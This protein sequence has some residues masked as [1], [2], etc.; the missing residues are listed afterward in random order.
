MVHLL[1]AV[2]YLSF[3]SLGLPDSL[4]GAAWPHI[5]PQMSV[6]VSYAGIISFIIACGTIV[7]SLLSDRLTRC[8]G[9]GKVTALSVLTTAVALFGF[10]RSTSFVTLALFAVPYGL[11]AGC[12]D[13]ALNNYVA[14]HYGSCHMSWL[15]SMWGL[16][17]S[18]GPVIMGSVL[19]SGGLWSSGYFIISV[20][21][22]SLSAVL[23]L[24]L[25]LWKRESGKDGSGV[26]EEE[27]SLPGVLRLPGVKET[28]VSFLCY[29]AL[30]QTT[31][32]WATSYLHLSRGFASSTSSALSSLFFI[33][34]T[35]GRIFG[36][37]LTMKKDDTA[38]VRIGEGLLLSGVVLLL[39]PLPSQFCVP[40]LVLTGL[41]CA[42]VY[43]AVIHSTPIRFPRRFSQSVIGVEMA[44]AYAGTCLLPPLFGIIAERTTTAVFPC[45]LAFFLVIM[46]LMQERA[47]RK[48]RQGA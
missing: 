11:G 10:S 37:F 40:A 47:V 27:V 15:H 20:I 7:S 33:G 19:S 44:F 43:P 36:G 39:L 5:Y 28:L 25:P 35:V 4:L 30:E 42:P 1:L 48:T 22:F 45:Y 2:I 16:G 46:T 26:K 6:P 38:M 3:I 24:S 32:L 29:S 8:L 18:A 13:A 12:V 21:Q 14:V 23:L 17:A 31:G 9:T 41:G 34:I